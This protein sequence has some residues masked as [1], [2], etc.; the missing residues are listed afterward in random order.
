MVVGIYGIIKAGAVY[1]PIN[2]MYPDDRV[3]YILKDCGANILLC[4]KT[5][6]KVD[7]NGE[8][9]DLKSDDVYSD[10]ETAPNA[11]ITPESG[12]YVIYTSGTTGTPKGAWRSCIETL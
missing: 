6:L 4:G 1:V 5:E 2:T 7:F 9:L 11:D 10:N 8:R 12:L 3:E